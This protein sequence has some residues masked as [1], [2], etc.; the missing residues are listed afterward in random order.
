MVEQSRQA[1][2]GSVREMLL[3]EMTKGHFAHSKRLPRESVLAEMLNISRTQLRDNLASLEREGFIS[4]CHGVGTIIN[5]HVL[6]VLVRMDIEIELM[7]MVRQSGYEPGLAFVKVRQEPCPHYVGKALCLDEDTPVLRVSRLVTA[8]GKAAV[9]CEDYIAL[10]DIEDSSYDRS[11]FEQ[12]I[13]S[14][15]SRYCKKTLVMDVTELSAVAA[16]A[17]LAEILQ[18]EQGTPLLFMDEIDYEVSGHPVL[19]SRQYYVNGII[20]HKVVRRRL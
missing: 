13:F 18:L 5:H 8:D 2:T 16:T 20:H 19:Y 9:Y 1:Y 12:P 10:S 11:I 15:I 6:D 4:R 17:E 7:D 3:Y 14:F